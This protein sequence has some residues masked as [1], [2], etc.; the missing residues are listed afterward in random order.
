M[1][2]VA[3][4]GKNLVPMSGAVNFKRTQSKHRVARRLLSDPD[5][6][7]DAAERLGPVWIDANQGQQLVRGVDGVPSLN[8]IKHVGEH[9]PWVGSDAY[10]ENVR[11]LTIESQGRNPSIGEMENGAPAPFR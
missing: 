11:E 10:G 3:G 5:I 8:S 1:R 6:H 9:W 4:L 7:N 2:A